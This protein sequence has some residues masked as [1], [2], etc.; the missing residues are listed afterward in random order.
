MLQEF[1][2]WFSERSPQAQRNI[3]LKL[4]EVFQIQNNP[5]Y[6][7]R[8]KQTLHEYH[9]K[10]KDL[11]SQF[12]N[13]VRYKQAQQRIGELEAYII[14]LEDRPISINTLYFNLPL[15]ERKEMKN[16]ITACFLYKNL[17]EINRKLH[18]KLK[19]YE[20]KNTLLTYDL[21]KLKNHMW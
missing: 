20:K 5:G 15:E 21:I 10:I 12:E 17:L 2:N 18:I 9:I 1:A 19:N 4:E 7:E 16:R 13:D 14:E 6:V 3:L 8:M 11:E